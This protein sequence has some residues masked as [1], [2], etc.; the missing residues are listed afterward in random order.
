LTAAESLRRRFAEREPAYGA[1][2]T[3]GSPL[4]GEIMAR[5]GFD[6]VCVDLQHGLAGIESAAPALQGIAAAGSLPLVRV[7][8]NE[9]WLVMR[10]LDLGA[11]GVIVPLVSS[12]AEAERAA[13]ACRYP[14]EGGRSW[15]PVRIAGEP[16]PAERNARVFCFV[17][18]ETR[19]GVAELDAIARTPGVDGVYVGPRDLALDHGFDAGSAELA[20]TVRRIG[21]RCAELGVPAGIHTRSGDAALRAIGDGYAFATIATDR[22]LLAG[23]AREELRRALRRDPAPRPPEDDDLVRAAAGYTR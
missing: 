2:T 15:G 10:A 19:D 9:P 18:V 17:M 11:G 8:G 16:A 12:R 21:H 22:D 14:P 5:L 3:L 20:E 6:Y 13:R 4:A 7:P 23:A 1:W